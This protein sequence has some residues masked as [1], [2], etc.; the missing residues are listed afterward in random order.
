MPNIDWNKLVDPQY[1][2][3]GIA[4]SSSITPAIENNSFFFWFFLYLF[5]GF[6]VLGIVMRVSQAFIHPEHPFQNKFPSW[7]NNLMW[8]GVLGLGWFTL[9]Q[10]NVG[11]L[12]ARIWLLF[13]AVWMLILFY[14]IIR[15]FALF[16]RLERAYFKKTHLPKA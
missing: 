3:E 4:G 11:F 6:L 5:S 12:G 10:L 2:L 15:Y 1:W 16:Y 9:R 8:F 13:G 7:A 14:F